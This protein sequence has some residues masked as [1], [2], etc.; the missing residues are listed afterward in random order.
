MCT[1]ARTIRGLTWY[2]V[3]LSP[4]VT[5]KRMWTPYVRGEG[6]QGDGRV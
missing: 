5:I 2:G 4:R 6:S 3:G 1:A